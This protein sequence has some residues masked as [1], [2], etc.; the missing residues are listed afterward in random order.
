[1]RISSSV[2]TAETM[3]HALMHRQHHCY[4]QSEH[5]DAHRGLLLIVPNATIVVIGRFMLSRP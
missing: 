2:W 1:M 5:Y 3:Q 4:E